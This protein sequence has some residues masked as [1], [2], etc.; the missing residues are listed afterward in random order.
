MSSASAG[1]PAP[2]PP[3]A[4]EKA[5]REAAL[6]TVAEVPLLFPG[7]RVQTRVKLRSEATWYRPPC[8]HHPGRH[9]FNYGARLFA[10]LLSPLDRGEPGDP[11]RSSFFR[12]DLERS[13]GPVT[14]ALVVGL[15]VTHEAAHMAVHLGRGGPGRARP[16]GPA[17]QRA[18]AELIARDLPRRAARP[19]SPAGHEEG[20]YRAPLPRVDRSP[21]RFTF[22]PGDRVAFPGSGGRLLQGLVLRVNRRSLSIAVDGEQETRWWRVAPHLLRRPGG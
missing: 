1:P 8:R 22:R 20:W 2:L 7:E 5:A 19:R 6:A 10:H 17:F 15:L 9:L 21:Q 4:W 18:L 13:H 3:H 14:P 16:H 11:V 12:H